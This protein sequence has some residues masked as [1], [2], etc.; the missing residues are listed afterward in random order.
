MNSLSWFLYFAD[1]PRSL[2][3]FLFLVGLIL[4]LGGISASIFGFAEDCKKWVVFGLS[5][6]GISLFFW[7]VTVLIPSKNTMYAIAVSELGQ[8]AVESELGKKGMEALEAW[9]DFTVKG[10]EIT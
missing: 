10:K 3:L 5:S 1:V 8:Q 9:I 6:I 2:R 4:I 7:A